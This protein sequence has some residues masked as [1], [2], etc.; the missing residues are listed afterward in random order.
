MVVY[1]VIGV[2]VILLAVGGFA[3]Y[4]IV[5]ICKKNQ[6]LRVSPNRNQ[7]P[8]GPAPS[9]RPSLSKK[10]DK[11]AKKEKKKGNKSKESSNAKLISGSGINSKNMELQDVSNSIRP[12]SGTIVSRRK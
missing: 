4:K 5:K 6:G 12:P 10:K 7:E 8:D 1:I 3:I 11:K 2:L 9:D